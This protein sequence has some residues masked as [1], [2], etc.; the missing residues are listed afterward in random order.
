M[1]KSLIALA[2]AGAIAAVPAVGLAGVGPDLGIPPSQLLTMKINT[3]TAALT[4]GGSILKVT[5]GVQA[6]GEQGFS[7]PIQ[8]DVCAGATG[9]KEVNVSVKGSGVKKG[10]VSFNLADTVQGPV[11]V[12]LQVTAQTQAFRSVLKTFTVTAS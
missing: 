1:R 4:T 7:Q 6:T 10:T 5:V 11:K 8:L 9:C 3:P 2:A 12:S